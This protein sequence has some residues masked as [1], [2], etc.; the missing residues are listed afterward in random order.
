MPAIHLVERSD[1][2]R[3]TDRT[4]NEWESGYWPLSEETAATLVGGSLLLHRNKQQPWLATVWRRL[5]PAD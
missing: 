5:P 3:K 4:S 1:H 2:V